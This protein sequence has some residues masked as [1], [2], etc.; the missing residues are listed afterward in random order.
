MAVAVLFRQGGRARET[1]LAV[2]IGTAVL[3][4]L[5][6][7]YLDA[8]RQF[9]RELRAY[10]ANIVITP[11]D[12]AGLL[13]LSDLDGAL[14]ELTG[15]KLVGAA[16]YIFGRAMVRKERAVLGQ[17]PQTVITGSLFPELR[18]VNPYWQV[19]GSWPQ[20]PNEAM[21]GIELAETLRLRPGERMV[22][23][24]GNRREVLS[25]ASV[26]KSGG[27]ED[28]QVFIALSLAQEILGRPGAADGMRLSVVGQGRELETV[29]RELEVRVPGITARPVGQ[30]AR[31][32]EVVLKRIRTLILLVGLA[33]TVSTFICLVTTMVSNMV[34][35]RLEMGLKK[36]LGASMRELAT[37]F[38]TE[39]GLLGLA[40]GTVGLPAG[41]ALTRVIGGS[42]FG[43]SVAFRWSVVPLALAMGVALAALAA[44]LPVWRVAE[45][46]PA[47]VLKGE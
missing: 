24:K 41:Y 16:P 31:A 35:R 45:L 20:R 7:V 44:W 32:E 43:G 26:V 23:E 37:E 21:V 14:A 27:A 39:A 5:A 8:T 13:R 9:S 3:A 18:A 29:A 28:A 11:R 2:A 19:N 30:I 34:E 10:G 4:A 12:G 6:N 42:I 33:M 1:I 15:E 36:A 17:K 25:V 40:G 22:L 38:V 46:R 47:T